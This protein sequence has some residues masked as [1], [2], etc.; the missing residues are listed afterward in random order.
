[1]VAREQI[2][3]DI[4]NGTLPQVSWVIP[5]AP[6]SDHP[7]GN[8]TLGMWWITDVVN[9]VMQSKYWKNTTKVGK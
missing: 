2:F 3:W 5:S 4:G 7:P 8:I 6:I 1:V 9:A